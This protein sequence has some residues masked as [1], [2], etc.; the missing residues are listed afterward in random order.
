MFDIIQV[1]A[2]CAFRAPH[3]ASLCSVE[4]LVWHMWQLRITVVLYSINRCHETPHKPHRRHL[5]V[6]GIGKMC[7]VRCILLI[8][9]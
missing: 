2:L 3:I 4:P 5:Q 9:I 7:L 1:L 6:L 8:S